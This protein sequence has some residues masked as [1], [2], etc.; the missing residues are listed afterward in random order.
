MEPDRRL[1][2]WLCYLDRAPRPSPLTQPRPWL[3]PECWGLAEAVLHCH[4]LSL[5]ARLYVHPDAAANIPAN[6]D[7]PARVRCCS[8]PPHCGRYPPASAR[9]PTDR[10]RPCR[11][12]AICS[13]GYTPSSM[14]Q[15]IKSRF[16]ARR[17]DTL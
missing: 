9:V 1:R 4:W 14:W 7:E 13:P 8:G 15:N 5:A 11:R 2:R 17:N 16:T 12:Y 10:Q 3:A 6:P